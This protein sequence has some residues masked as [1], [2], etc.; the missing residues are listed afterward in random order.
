M[1]ESARLVFDSKGRSHY[2][3][4]QQYTMSCGP[5]CVAMTEHYYK[6]MCMISPEGRAQ[7]LSQRYPGS[8]SLEKG[9]L[10]ENL[11]QVLCKEGIKVYSP[12][13][14]PQDKTFDYFY[15]YVGD[16]TPAIALVKWASGGGHF[17]VCRMIDTDHT[18]VFLD[19]IHGVV[20]VARTDLP[21]YRSGKITEAIFTHR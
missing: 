1:P 21:R 10:T 17:V 7:V 15:Q 8:F 9:T 11:Y 2:V 18:M 20:E 16:K 6:G 3:C 4:D 5:A 12:I 13:T 14:V 19:P